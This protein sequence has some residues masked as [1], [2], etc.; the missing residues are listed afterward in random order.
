MPGLKS[1]FKTKLSKIIKP[2]LASSVVASDIFL[3]YLGTDIQTVEKAFEIVEK[4]QLEL[5]SKC[6]NNLRLMEETIKEIRDNYAPAET[7]RQR[8]WVHHAGKLN[9]LD[10]KLF[11]LLI[12]DLD[13]LIPEKAFRIIELLRFYFDI[14][15]VLIIMGINDHILN[16]YVNE[17]YRAGK[18]KKGERFLEKIFHW[19]YELSYTEL[20]K[21]HSRSLQ[22][23]LG[24]PDIE[25]AESILSMLDNVAHRKWIKV[26]NRV[27]DIIRSSRPPYVMEKVVFSAALRELYPEFELFTRKFRMLSVICIP[28]SR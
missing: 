6:R 18:N 11:V 26:M 12:D 27:E 8:L 13:R 2:L 1:T 3:K 23:I 10:R 7:E 22:N 24:P 25:K 16:G 28:A 9:R 5:I 19:N 14:D 15:N 21:V 4:G 20:N 17:H